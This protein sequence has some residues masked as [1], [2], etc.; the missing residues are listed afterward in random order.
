MTRK[1]QNI[2]YGLFVFGMC[3]L[4]LVAMIIGTGTFGQCNN[5]KESECRC[6]C[7]QNETRNK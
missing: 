6:S 5:Q 1:P 7:N 3:V 2:V 4:F